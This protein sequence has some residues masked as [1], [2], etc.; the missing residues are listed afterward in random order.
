M[1]IVNQYRYSNKQH[2]EYNPRHAL[3][4]LTATGAVCWRDVTKQHSWTEYA[5]LPG[6]VSVIIPVSLTHT[7]YDLTTQTYP[8]QCSM[9]TDRPASEHLCSAAAVRI[10]ALSA[11]AQL[12]VGLQALNEEKCIA[13]TL[14]SIQSLDPLPHETILVDGGSTDRSVLASR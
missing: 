14:Q 11:H 3:Q 5:G 2:A 6:K 13:E 7:A 9:S 10:A 4:A 8:T 1:V 12:C